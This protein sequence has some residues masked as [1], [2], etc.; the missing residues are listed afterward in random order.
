MN[1]IFFT[2]ALSG[3]I[4]ILFFLLESIFFSNHRVY[5]NIFQMTEQE[6]TH[7]KL[8]FFNQGFYNLFLA[9]G[10]F[11][12]IYD[13]IKSGTL[14]LVLYTSSFMLGASIVLFLSKRKLYKG[15]LLQGLIPLLT[16]LL[17]IFKS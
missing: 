8:I 3:L 14:D 1:L 4:H 9:A 15:A 11:L 7:T 16:I 5:K 6:M 10:T 2:A 12:G 13:S 17:I